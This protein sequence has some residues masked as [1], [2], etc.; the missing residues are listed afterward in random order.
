VPPPIET[1]RRGWEIG[2]RPTFSAGRLGTGPTG[3]LF[4]LRIEQLGDAW[5]M[6]DSV[7]VGVLARDHPIARL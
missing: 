5:L 4:L 1:M 3:S 2:P 6:A 7:E